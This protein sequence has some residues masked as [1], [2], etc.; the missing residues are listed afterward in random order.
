[1]K[2]IELIKEE[3]EFCKKF[4]KLSKDINILDKKKKLWGLN[5]EES[6][7]LNFLILDYM[8]YYYKLVD[9][10]F[11]KYIE[12]LLFNDNIIGL[13]QELLLLLEWDG[14]LLFFEEDIEVF[15]NKINDNNR[16]YIIELLEDLS[17]LEIESSK[18]I[19]F[20]DE[21]II[22]LFIE[23]N[24]IENRNECIIE[25]I[26]IKYDIL[27]ELIKEGENG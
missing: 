21:E 14:E 18:D 3:K 10:I 26:K 12:P 13:K 5:S 16:Q 25:Y 15:M 17:H 23:L 9:I 6:I 24:N 19:K 11:N 2:S 27:I 7:K 1:M 22:S 20:E 4:E 8:R